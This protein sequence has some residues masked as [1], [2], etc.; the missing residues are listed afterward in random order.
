MATTHLPVIGGHPRGPAATVRNDNWWVGPAAVFAYITV[1]VTYLN[2][3]LF[4]GEYY[5][6]APYLSPLYSPV[7]FA[8]PGAP[9]GVPIEHAWFGTWPSWWPG[10]LPASPAFFALVGPGALRFTCYYYRKAYYRSFAGSPPACGV[11]PITKREYRGEAGLMVF[12]N[13]HRYAMYISLV[14]LPILVYDAVI[15][16]SREG[17]L[18]IGVGTIVLCI[19]TALLSSYSFGCHSFRH[20][21]AGHDDCMSCGENTAKYSVWKFSTWFNERHMQIAMISLFWVAFTDFYV[22]MVAMG[23]IHDFNTWD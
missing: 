19:N 14:Y 9:G 4:Q 13:L 15:A 1:I 2:W 6:A 10:F 3:A 5:Y 12:Q 7:L 21:F 16:F 23:Y 22:R 20:V 11:V 17:Q 8:V 18:G